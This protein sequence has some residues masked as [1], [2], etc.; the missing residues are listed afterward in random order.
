MKK[1]KVTF[2]MMGAYPITLCLYVY[3]FK[4]VKSLK[5]PDS[6]QVDN[7]FITLPSYIT[8]IEEVSNE[9]EIFE[10]Y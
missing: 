7:S 8:N 4:V 2:E 6:I 3:G 5:N 10:L 1:F 9:E